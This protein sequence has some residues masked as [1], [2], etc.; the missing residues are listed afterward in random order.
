MRE[1]ERESE[2]EFKSAR[3]LNNRGCAPTQFCQQAMLML[4]LGNYC[5]V[6]GPHFSFEQGHN[7]YL[8][9]LSRINTNKKY[10]YNYKCKT[11]WHTVLLKFLNSF[12]IEFWLVLIH[13]FKYVLSILATFCAKH[14]RCKDNSDIFLDLCF[15]PGLFRLRFHSSCID[16]NLLPSST[17]T[18]FISE[19]KLPFL[20]MKYNEIIRLY[21]CIQNQH[22]SHF[23][24]TAN[25]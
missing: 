18:F 9:G 21:A 10:M 20:C 16:W 1:R 8:L 22:L 7:T 17:H 11:L 15:I 5:Y 3:K 19:L 4:T 12:F 13:L 25:F 23:W 6:P 24:K 14:S 2:R